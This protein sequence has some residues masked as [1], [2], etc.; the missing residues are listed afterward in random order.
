MGF[1]I[2]RIQVESKSANHFLCFYLVLVSLRLN[3]P[4]HITE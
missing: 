1:I 2:W 4:E 3:K